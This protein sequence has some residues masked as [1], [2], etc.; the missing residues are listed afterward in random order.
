MGP[1]A[2]VFETVFD[3]ALV[4]ILAS[5]KVYSFLA[6]FIEAAFIEELLK[7]IALNY[8]SYRFITKIK[9]KRNN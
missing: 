5:Y 6:S 7:L 2:Y 3:Y 1:A 9:K 8:V 4:S